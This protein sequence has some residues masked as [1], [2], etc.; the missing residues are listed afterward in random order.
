MASSCP[1]RFGHAFVTPSHAQTAE[2][3][4]SS[5]LKRE[6][7]MRDEISPSLSS[8]LKVADLEVFHHHQILLVPHQLD[9]LQKSEIRWTYIPPSWSEDPE[10]F[11]WNL[12]CWKVGE[13]RSFPNLRGPRWWLL[14]AFHLFAKC[15]LLRYFFS[16]GFVPFLLESLYTLLCD[17]F[18]D[19]IGTGIW[20]GKHQQRECKLENGV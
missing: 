10:T 11:A 9:H 15:N 5:R 13:F 8:A 18:M 4:G 14:R 3:F 2:W 12:N 20:G 1:L 19:Y 6:L 17:L 7:G 16:H